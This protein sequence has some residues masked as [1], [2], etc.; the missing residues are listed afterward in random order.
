MLDEKFNLGNNTGPYLN[1][2]AV[3]KSEAWLSGTCDSDCPGNCTGGGRRQ[4]EGNE[5]GGVGKGKCQKLNKQSEWNYIQKSLNPG[6][7]DKP[8][9]DPFLRTVCKSKFNILRFICTKQILLVK[10]YTVH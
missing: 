4:C 2:H 10:A 3:S 8:I 9:I 6:R 1:V 7:D 5:A